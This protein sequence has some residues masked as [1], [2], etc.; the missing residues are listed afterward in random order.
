MADRGPKVATH[1]ATFACGHCGASL[2]FS[3]VRTETCPYC[4]SPN[5]VERP[6]AA[7]RPDPQFVVAFT[8]DGG[9]AKLQLDRWIGKRSLF[10]DSKLRHAKAADLRGVYVPA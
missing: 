5:F 4:A 7:H 10:S 8:G 9:V 2:A 1:A 3:G 6:P